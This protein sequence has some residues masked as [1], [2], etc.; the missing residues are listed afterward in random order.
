M[1]LRTPQGL[2]IFLHERM[3][4]YYSIHLGGR[5]FIVF[6]TNVAMNTSKGWMSDTSYWIT[7]LDK[8]YSI[9]GTS[10]F[11]IDLTEEFINFSN[12]EYGDTVELVDFYSIVSSPYPHILNTMSSY[13]QDKWKTLYDNH[14]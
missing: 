5:D 7:Y 14:R 3:Y 12:G 10:S 13:T 8:E 11:D 2:H 1:I 4:D 6:T 9:K